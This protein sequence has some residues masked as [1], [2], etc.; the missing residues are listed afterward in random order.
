MDPELK[1]EAAKIGMTASMGVV[2]LTS[3][4][5]KNRTMK[6]LHIGAGVALAGFSFWHHL[7]YQPEKNPEKHW[8]R[9]RKL[10]Q[11]LS[12]SLLRRS[13]GARGNL[14][15]FTT[16]LKYFHNIHNTLSLLKYRYS[17]GFMRNGFLILVTAAM[18]TGTAFGASD[19][20]TQS[21]KLS[22]QTNTTL[23]KSQK[24]ID[25]LD[26]IRQAMLAEYDAVSRELENYRVYNKQLQEIVDSQHAEMA[27][28][29]RQ[30][31]EIEVT[32]REIMPLMERMIDTL[33][34]FVQKDRP[35]LP[36]ERAARI[37]SLRADMKRADLSIAAKYRQ[38]L[39]S[40]QIEIEYGNT[41]EAYQGNVEGKQ[42][43]FLKVG[44]IGLYYQSRDGSRSAVWNVQTGAW[45]PL[46]GSEYHIAIAKAIKIARKR[47]S[48]E[49]FFAAVAPA[50]ER[51]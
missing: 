21:R 27:A 23:Q 47:R 46:E 32:K 1:K 33:E 26:D 50:K 49:L 16:W 40:Y 22:T 44:R 6:N 18:I 2:V 7:L 38:I 24:S 35:F 12:L 13:S 29:E 10:K 42:V 48:P 39:E 45:Q 37:A 28:L 36:D 34:R 15:W 14:V 20:L 25:N 17:R 19:G 4:Y 41:I 31:G 51:R 11:F 3:L 9:K 30:S 5:M 43:D 8:R